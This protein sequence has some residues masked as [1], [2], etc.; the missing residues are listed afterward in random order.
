MNVLLMDDTLKRRATIKEAIEKSKNKVNDCYSSND[1]I[2]FLE[3]EP[4]DLVVL[5]MDTW[6]KGKS[7]Y[8]YF[9]ISKKLENIPV[10]LY[11]AEEDANFVPDRSRHDRDRT[12][13]KP[14]ELD[15]IVD[16]I[17]QII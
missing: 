13:S 1:F 9:R 17:Q 3:N 4:P 8:N 5:D 15:T 16:T 7:I 10:V 12:L 6:K 2:T 11:N 14:S